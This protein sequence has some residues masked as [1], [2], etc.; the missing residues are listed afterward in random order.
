MQTYVSKNLFNS[1]ELEQAKGKVFKD[2]IQHSRIRK[3]LSSLE[4]NEKL[5]IIKQDRKSYSL[6]KQVDFW[7]LLKPLLQPP[8]LFDFPDQ[9]D[10]YKPLRGYQQQGISW[11]ANNS[12]ALLADEMGTGKTVQTVNALR[13]LFRQGK[14]KSALIICPAAVLGS[15]E[16]SVETEKPEGWSGHFYL[17]A[18]ELFVKVIIGSKKKREL[19]WKMLVHLYITTYDTIRNDLS[20]NLLTDLNKFDCVIL[21]EAQIIKNRNTSRFKAIRKLQSQYRWALTGTPIENSIEDIKSIFEF[22]HPGLFN[23]RVDYSHHE[24]RS[25]I[26]PYMLRRLKK[27]VLKELPEKIYQED[28]LELDSEQQDAYDKALNIGRQKIKTSLNHEGEVKTHIFTLIEE[29]KQICNFAKNKNTSPK[30]ERMFEY[31]ETIIANDQKVVIFSQYL[32][33]GVDKIAILLKQ[34]NI[35][36]VMYKGGLTGKQRDQAINDFRSKLDVNVFLGTTKAVGVGITLT[37]AS[38]LIHFDQLWNPTQMQQAE[39]R[40]HRIGQDKNITIYSFWMK[41][42]IEERI[43]KKLIEKRLLIENIID[44]LA[45]DVQEEYITIEEWLDILDIRTIQDTNVNLAREKSITLR[46]EDQRIQ[47]KLAGLQKQYD[48]LSEKINVIRETLVTT[49]STVQKFDLEKQLEKA[50]LERT[51]LEQQMEVFE[52]KL[53][54]N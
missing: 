16:L 35:N 54:A 7:D 26:D 9:I 38:Y 34:K 6:T 31:I 46:Q 2:E 33:Q 52:D 21:D 40:V 32:Q 39:D 44:S 5:F 19:A 36:F 22:I 42:T 28:W 41:G 8:L 50:E 24:I 3:N 14:I 1:L 12:S 10:L 23:A 15:I 4:N 48:L 53:Q 47:Q 18:P 20:E 43:K 30:T 25:M 11:L 27:D 37:E 13:L 49:S 51:Q 17:W 45:V 29:L